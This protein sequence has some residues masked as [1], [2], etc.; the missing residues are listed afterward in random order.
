MSEYSCPMLKQAEENEDGDLIYTE[1]RIGPEGRE[2]EY[3]LNCT[4]LYSP[5]R[6]KTGDLEILLIEAQ[7][8]AEGKDLGNPAFPINGEIADQ[9]HERLPDDMNPAWVECTP[10]EF[11]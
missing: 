8:A 10:R 2:H 1:I 4:K 7:L 5:G 9:L 6:R 11:P 3:E